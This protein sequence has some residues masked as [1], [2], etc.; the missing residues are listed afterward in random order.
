MQL[1]RMFTIG[2]TTRPTVSEVV[3]PKP[4]EVV[5]CPPSSCPQ[6]GNL[7]ARVDMRKRFD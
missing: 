2:G 6:D 1:R 3:T 4:F 7:A 5:I